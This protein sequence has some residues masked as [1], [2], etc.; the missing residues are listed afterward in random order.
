MHVSNLL[1][2]SRA[3]MSFTAGKGT[4]SP[5]CTWIGD[6]HLFLS[7]ALSKAGITDADGKLQAGVTPGEAQ[8]A[9]I[10]FIALRNN[11]RLESDQRPV[12]KYTEPLRP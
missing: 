12:A 10:L 7:S 11:P 8:T 6:A 2:A 1:T 9:V 3:L 4:I 5:F